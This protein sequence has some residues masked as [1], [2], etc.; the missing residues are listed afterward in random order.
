M[1]P[2][3]MPKPP[4]NFQR[5]GIPGAGNLLDPEVRGQLR[6]QLHEAVHGAKDQMQQQQQGD[7]SDESKPAEVATA[8]PPA[9]GRPQNTPGSDFDLS[10]ISANVPA[11][12]AKPQRGKVRRFYFLA[13]DAPHV[14]DGPNQSA[15]PPKPSANPKPG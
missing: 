5:P 11:E 3:G 10:F 9:P 8:P 15:P 4:E 13:D 14:S 12:P 7:T 1:S 2:Q 6:E